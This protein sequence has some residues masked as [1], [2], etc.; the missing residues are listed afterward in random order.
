MKSGFFIAS[1]IAFAAAAAEAGQSSSANYS[2]TA[3]SI[4]SGG[5]IA[6]AG[7]YS[8]FATVGLLSGTAN[9]VSYAERNGAAGAQPSA[10]GLRVSSASS[11]VDTGSS[12][13]L[14]AATLMDDSTATFVPASSVGWSVASGPVA[15]IDS[16]GLATAATGIY[17]DAGATVQGT[18]AGFTGSL[19]L[20]VVN[21]AYNAWVAQYFGEGN[22]EGAPN[23]DANGTGQTN[24]FK[25][26]AGLD[27][28]DS[29]SKFVV[30]IAPVTGQPNQRAITYSP[31]V[32][33]RTY[34]VQYCTELSAPNWHPLT[35]V[36]QTQNGTETSVVDGNPT[37]SKKFYRVLIS[38]P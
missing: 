10:V 8:N 23:V 12:I 7:S 29:H 5:Q 20:T 15:A 30:A 18:Y 13:Q 25:Y 33:G 34:T 11:V 19:R 2:I 36:S 21:A 3:D 35:P 24:L 27:P 17:E 1:I 28:S 26:L 14:S 22:P 4:N 31:V 37:D 38:M 9:S 16:N 6:N 32:A